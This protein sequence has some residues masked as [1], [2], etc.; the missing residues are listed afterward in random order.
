MKAIKKKYHVHG[1]VTLP[2]SVE[3]EAVNENA[4]QAIAQYQL[5]DLTIQQALLTLI[6]NHGKVILPEIHNH[7]IDIENTFED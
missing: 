3:I 4:A 7:E 1:T 5:N 6:T 2:F